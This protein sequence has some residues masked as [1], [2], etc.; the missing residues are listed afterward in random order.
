MRLVDVYLPSANV[1]ASAELGSGNGTRAGTEQELIHKARR[2]RPDDPDQFGYGER[3]QE[4]LLGMYDQLKGRAGEPEP[5]PEEPEKVPSPAFMITESEDED[6]DARGYLDVEEVEEVGVRVT[7]PTD[8]SRA[9]SKKA[10]YS[11]KARC[12]SVLKRWKGNTPARTFDVS[13]SK[14]W[15]NSQP[16]VVSLTTLA[17]TPAFKRDRMSRRVGRHHLP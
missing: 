6:E 11:A 13:F 10:R 12:C 9:R 14:Q 7:W 17:W 16:R 1:S 8:R 2:S 4:R 5:K 3:I 15:L